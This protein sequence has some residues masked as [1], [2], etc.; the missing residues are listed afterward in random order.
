MYSRSSQ[1]ARVRTGHATRAIVCRAPLT[2]MSSNRLKAHPLDVPALGE[3]PLS[4]LSWPIL[5]SQQVWQTNLR[6]F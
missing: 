4:R 5:Q 3:A 6:G 2:I 1:I